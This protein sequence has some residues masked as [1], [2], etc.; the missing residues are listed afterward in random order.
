MKRSRLLLIGLLVIIGGGCTRDPAARTRAYIESG[1]AFERA[2]KHREASIA[3]RNAI[4]LTPTSS[5]AYDKLAR[6]A[7]RAQDSRTAAAAILRAAELKP[8]DSAAQVRAASLYLL[9]GRHDDARER[10]HAA[11]AV[12]GHDASA[13][14]VLAQAL[15]GL[16]DSG[17]SEAAMREAVRLAP[18]TPAPHIALGSHHWSAGHL[19]EAEAEFRRAVDIAPENVSANRALALFLMATD[20]EADADPLWR[21]VATRPDGMPFARADYLV[22]VNRLAD[23][24]KELTELIARTGGRADEARIRLAAVAYVQQKPEAAH[25][26]L[27]LVLERD[28]RS[29]PALLLH[30]RILLGEHRFDEAHRAARAAAAANPSLAAAAAMQ[31]AIYAAQGEEVAAVRA[32]ET[33]SKLNPNDVAPYVVMARVRLRHGHAADAVTAAERARTI[34]PDAKAP[35]LVL[36]EALAHSGRGPRAIEEAEAAIAKWPRSPDFH[37]QLGLLRASAGQTEAAR[38]SLSTALQLHPGSMDALAALADLDVRTGRG[39]AALARISR[40]VDAEPDN[41]ALSFLLAQVQGAI[42]ATTEAEA[43]LRG[44]VHRDPSQLQAFFALGRLYLASGRLEDARGEFERLSTT[45]PDGS[46]QTM[47][48]IILQ[49]QNRKEQARRAFEQAVAANPRAGVAANNLAWLYQEEG[50]WDDALKWAAVAN[51][52]LGHVP[53]VRDTL[54]WIQVQR[55]AFNIGLPLLA[56]NVAAQPDNPLYRYHLGYAYWKTGSTHAAAEQLRHAL[57]SSSEFD[58]RDRAE[59]IL[60]DLAAAA[61]R[62]EP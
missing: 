11:L 5:E 2:G 50:R 41:L 43:T 32:F 13:Q 59:R 56:S 39:A 51:R 55:G 60:E 34:R 7:A 24:E 30:A 45:D 22:T 57:A 53:E 1:E 4:K 46:A 6:A 47:V 21:V 28:P 35:R 49:S 16:H 27:R 48:G 29:V 36:I 17:G 31:G 26:T 3:Y 20:R 8:D 12:D 9:V 15:A 54:G 40:R 52:Q 62:R 19:A 44:I 42:G 25:E 38:R 23:A 33:A 61:D 14:L 37:M 58:G 10:A 18:R